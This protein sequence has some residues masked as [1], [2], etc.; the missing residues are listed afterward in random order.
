MQTLTTFYWRFSAERLASVELELDLDA[1]VFVLELV[2]LLS[3]SLSDR[4][5]VLDLSPPGLSTG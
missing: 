1:E 2:P 3:L 5:G 4:P